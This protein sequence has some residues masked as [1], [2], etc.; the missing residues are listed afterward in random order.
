MEDKITLGQAIAYLFF[1]KE[2][3]QMPE[4]LKDD[5]IDYIN[6]LQ[7]RLKSHNLDK[8]R[9]NK[10]IRTNS[11]PDYTDLFISMFL[12]ENFDKEDPEL[13]RFFND[14]LECFEAYTHVLHDFVNKLDDLRN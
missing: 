13:L 9:F 5:D 4:S 12:N 7:A 10:L 11:Q 2:K 14:N 3:G 8:K 1:A 6:G